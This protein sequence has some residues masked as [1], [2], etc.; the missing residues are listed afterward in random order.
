MEWLNDVQT[1]SMKLSME[2]IEI[3]AASLSI[4]APHMAS[5]LL[6]QI[7]GKKLS[8]GSMDAL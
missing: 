6:E 7:Q 5:E 2:S 4:M 1:Q 3:V 8:G